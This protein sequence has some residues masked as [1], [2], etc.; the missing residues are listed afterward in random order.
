MN[1]SSEELALLEYPPLLRQIDK[2]QAEI[3]AAFLEASKGCKISFTQAEFTWAVQLVRSRAFTGPYEGRGPQ[4]RAAQLAF[5]IVLL[6]LS[7]GGG[8]VSLENGLNGALAAALAIPLTD[9]LVGQTSTLKRH[10][11]CPVVDYLN[12]DSSAISDIAYE[13]FANEFAVRVNGS[14]K[15]GEEVCINY[16]EQRSTDSLL[17]FYGFVERDNANDM[18]AMDILK[19]L[20][21]AK[22]EVLEVTLTRTGPRDESMTRLLTA[23]G[24][25]GDEEEAMAWQAVAMACEAEL[26]ERT[27][28]AAYEAEQGAGPRAL[29]ARFAA[30]KEKVLIACRAHA[31]SR[32]GRPSTAAPLSLLTRA[33][34]IPSFQEPEHWRHSWALEAL[35]EPA[36]SQLREEGF[37][38]ITG[39]FD[40]SLAA[41][42]LEECRSLDDSS[43]TTVT[44]N[45]CNR[46]SRS[47]WLDLDGLEELQQKLPALAKLSTMLAGLPLELQNANV[48]SGVHLQVHPATMI[49]VYPEQAAAY[50]LHK[51]SYAPADNDPATGATRHLTI[52]A[53]F[54]DWR[55]GHG[56]ELRIHE[57]AGQR[58]DPRHFQALEPKAGTVVIFDS[59]KVWH[60]VAPSLRGDR[61]AMTL[62]VH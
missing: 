52:L 13:Y 59:R 43:A 32:C 12:H 37:C 20:D 23:L 1:W 3:S 29:A 8:F 31:Q 27:A 17:Q 47:A 28:G 11:L 14:F 45:R 54:N 57:S 19:H 26:Q 38:C 53:Y 62:W 48:L 9:F 33:I 24:G 22:G 60:A 35:T 41:D 34:M 6:V 36:L 18:Y 10:V 25:D 30:E 40:A 2:Q 44:S 55:P 58:P 7:V 56:G 50:A 46:G 5:I 51:D 16:G 4:D 39:A 61:W 21:V 49:A 15:E 42:C